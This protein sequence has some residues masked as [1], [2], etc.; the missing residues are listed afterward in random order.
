MTLPWLVCSD[1]DPTP[2]LC[3]PLRERWLLLLLWAGEWR[4]ALGP[5]LNRQERQE[6][7]EQEK[8]QQGPPRR[9]R[10][11]YGSPPNKMLIHSEEGPRAFFGS[12][13]IR[14]EGDCRGEQ[15]LA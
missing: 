1:I 14:Y 13:L 8:E 15:R 5:N 2:F 11:R 10:Y 12:R 3:L 7:Q 6:H 9:R 4:W